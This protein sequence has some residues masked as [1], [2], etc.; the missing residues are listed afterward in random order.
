MVEEEQEEAE[1]KGRRAAHYFQ[2]L[3]QQQTHEKDGDI[4]GQPFPGRIFN[5]KT[6][7]HE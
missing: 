5:S 3:T 4:L 1:D 2:R 6:R 7:M